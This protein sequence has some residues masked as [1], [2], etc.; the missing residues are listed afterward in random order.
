M[1]QTSELSA[2]RTAAR[3]RQASGERTPPWSWF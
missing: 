2:A 1:M 3:T